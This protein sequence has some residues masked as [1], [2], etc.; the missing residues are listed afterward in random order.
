MTSAMRSGAAQGIKHFHRRFKTEHA[1]FLSSIEGIAAETDCAEYASLLLKR[2]MVVYFLQQH[3]LLDGNTDYLFNRLHVTRA[4]WGEDAFYHS[5]LLGFFHEELTKQGQSSYAQSRFGTIPT[6]AIPLFTIHPLEHGASAISIADEAFIRLFTFFDDYQWCLDDS[7]TCSGNVLYP[8]VLGFVFEQQVN[9]KQ[10]GAY[11]TGGDVAE[12]I[13]RNTVIPCL[14]ERMQER[15]PSQPGA[16]FWQLLRCDP[17]RYI[18]QAMRTREYLPTETER[19][20]SMRRRRYQE[21]HDNLRAGKV[22]HI[23]DFVTYNLNIRQFAAD[24]LAQSK[25]P[26]LL[27]AFYTCLKELTLLDPTCGSG[28]F[29]L[30]ALDILESLYDACL[31]RME[32]LREDLGYCNAEHFDELHAILDQIEQLPNRRYFILFSILN[33]NLYGVDIMA[34]AVEVCQLRLLLKLCASTTYANE[35]GPLPGVITSI[36][37]G[38][39]LTFDWSREFHDIVER[40][41]FDVII[42]NPPYIEYSKIRRSME[43]HETK[44]YGNLYAAIVERSLALCRPEQ[45]YLGLLVPLSICSGERFDSLRASLLQH[46][47]SLW[48]SNFEIFPCRLFKHAFQRLSFLLARHGTAQ[49]CNVHVTKIQRWYS[50]ERAHLMQVMAYTQAHHVAEQRVFPKLACS[51]QESILHKVVERAAGTCIADALSLE[52]TAFFV[53]YQEAINYWIKASRRVPFYKKNNVVKNP[54][55]GRFLFFA[56]ERTASAIMA[57]MNSSLF[58][59][60]FVTFSDGFHLSHALVKF[61]PIGESL[62]AIEELVLLSTQLEQDIQVHAKPSTRNVRSS[63]G[64]DSIGIEEYKMAHSKPLLDQIDHVL[65]T[66]YG[67]TDEELDFITNYDSKYRMGQANC[68]E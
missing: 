4:R 46:T 50:A 52:R 62:T 45:S 68:E 23:S 41:G 5:F 36:R 40:G 64:E 26:D 22:C 7:L 37:V 8:D 38:N 54:A 67:L 29:L 10:M 16:L 47:S 39:T 19:E 32:T 11:Y 30:T 33:S 15:F 42:G 2:L 20:Y 60:W 53:Y 25:S 31:A 34:E 59:L 14:F 1:F 24:V 65:A 17:H 55:H 21:L 58:Y 61:F 12:Y 13:T 57:L 49:Q 51:L 66:Y 9:Q 43:Q 6:L 44:N 27:Y 35:I 18:Q 28:A 56:E 48:L 63:R 3:G